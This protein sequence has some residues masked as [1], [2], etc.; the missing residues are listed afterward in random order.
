M[1]KNE[2]DRSIGL[3]HKERIV[4]EFLKSS[5]TVD[6]RINFVIANSLI[7]EKL[8]EQTF[9][10]MREGLNESDQNEFI[11]KLVMREWERVKN[12]KGEYFIRGSSIYSTAVKFA[13]NQEYKNDPISAARYSQNTSECV[14][15]FRV[16]S[17]LVGVAK[18]IANSGDL[19]NLIFPMISGVITDNYNR[20]WEE[21]KKSTDPTVAETAKKTYMSVANASQKLKKLNN[22]SKK[23]PSDSDSDDLK[24]Y[25]KAVEELTSKVKAAKINETSSPQ[26]VSEAVTPKTTT[27][28]PTTPRSADQELDRPQ[29]PRKERPDASL[30]EKRFGKQLSAED[31]KKEGTIIGLHRSKS[32]ETINPRSPSEAQTERQ[33]PPAPENSPT[34]P[35]ASPGGK[36]TISGHRDVPQKSTEQKNENTTQFDSPPRKRSGAVIGTDTNQQQ[37]VAST[38]EGK[39]NEE[40]ESFK[41]KTDELI[42]L[43]EKVF[44][45]ESKSVD[46]AARKEAVRSR[47]MEL[48]QQTKDP[49]KS[50]IGTHREEEKVLPG[51]AKDMLNNS[52]VQKAKAAKAAETE[53]DKKPPPI[54][55]TPS[56]GSERG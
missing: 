31:W 13:V 16:P 1:K 9:H 15:D 36:I 20:Q 47:L 14:R 41:A 3:L 46:L 27:S 40:L 28:P 45:A 52:S 26:P 50:A 5:P 7:G 8:G 38:Q 4:Q 37:R 22:D 29:S 32:E 55:S 19:A 11:S 18:E 43:D 30:R 24:E 39:P 51:P 35:P 23:P 34:S 6:E 42:S 25:R 33:G 44:E 2:L 48:R 10:L 17:A 56:R 49:A 12:S 54:L 21:A 53:D